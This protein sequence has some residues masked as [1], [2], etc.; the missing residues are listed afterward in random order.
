MKTEFPDFTFDDSVVTSNVALHK[1]E[2]KDSTG[3]SFAFRIDAT[4]AD[5]KDVI[6]TTCIDNRVSFAQNLKY[7]ND[8]TQFLATNDFQNSYFRSIVS[9]GEDAIPFILEEIKKKPSFLVRALDEILPGIVEYGEGYISIEQ[10]CE[11]WIS[12][13][14]PTENT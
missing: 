3:P 9:M 8:Q 11:T 5:G 10:V 13:L 2:F 12:I 1:R 7:W 6:N 4:A 14:S